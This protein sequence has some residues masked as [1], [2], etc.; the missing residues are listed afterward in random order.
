MDYFKAGSVF[1]LILL[2]TGCGGNKSQPAEESINS[3]TLFISVDETLKP[4]ME[5]EF[6]V[7][8][9]LNPKAKLVVSYIPEMQALEEF[10][11]DSTRA[12]ILSRNLT[13]DEMDYFRSIS[14]VPRALP[15]AKDG[16]A[17]LVNAENK[18]DSFTVDE[19]RRIFSGNLE[20]KDLG[21][22]VKGK[23]NMVFDNMASSTV[24]WIRDSIT[25]K[26]HFSSQ[27][28]A[29]QINPE[30]IKY[31]MENENAIGVI[32]NSWVSD[33]DDSNVVKALHKV[34]KA[35]IALN[36]TSEYLQPFQTEIET[37]RY[38]LSRMI[39]SIQRDGKVGLG[40]GVQRFLYDER[41]Q[42]IVLKFGMMPFRQPERSLEFRQ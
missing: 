3:G 13:S 6:T 40:T 21:G 30:V 31:V 22:N 16:I 25:G 14:F 15:F 35:R 24:R 5:A 34:K 36:D 1:F 18:K 8:S 29:V 12:V 42:L 19:L 17:F 39:Y 33:L 38:P 10:R 11:K 32:G 20:W 23:V 4:L 28:F 9:Y 26:T 41:G 2:F 27:C 7:F 37:D